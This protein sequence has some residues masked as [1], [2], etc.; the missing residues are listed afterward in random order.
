[1]SV[2]LY[3]RAHVRGM[4]HQ[5]TREGLINWPSKEAEEEAADAIADTLPEE[6]MAGGVEPTGEEVPPGATPEE[7]LSAEEAAV[8]LDQIVDVANQIAE[9]TGGYYDM[10]VNKEAA[11]TDYDE[12]ASMSVSSLITKIAD[13]D[14]GNLVTGDGRFQNEM[15]AG[16][17]PMDIK[18]NPP[19]KWMVDRGTTNLDTSP[20]A[21]GQEVAQEPTGATDS[22]PAEVAKLSALLKFMSAEG[23][24][25]APPGEGRKDLNDNMSMQAVVG[26]GKTKQEI[27]AAAVVGTLKPNPAGPTNRVTPA[28]DLD[29]TSA[30]ELRK[31]A[32]AIL[33]KLGEKDEDEKDEDEDEKEDSKKDKKEDALEN[34]KKL[35]ES[36]DKT[37]AASALLQALRNVAYAQG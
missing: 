36:G 18:M 5:L 24:N 15:A 19:G 10:G 11:Y 12:A 34:L 31:V 21:V 17:G 9:K 22:T 37:A 30:A 4:A 1:M 2:S 29:K 13:E 32:R 25:T 27:P 16:E 7:G 35:N 28:N 23:S 20:G 3:K 26:I 14:V 8:V 33:S 6:A